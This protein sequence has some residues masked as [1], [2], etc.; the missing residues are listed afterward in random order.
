MRTAPTTRDRRRAGDTIPCPATGRKMTVED[1]LW[2]KC[3]DLL[4]SWGCRRHR[5]FTERDGDRDG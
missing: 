4:P 2:A 5:P 3:D 1:C